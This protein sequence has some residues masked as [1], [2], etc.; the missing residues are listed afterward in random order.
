MSTANN[1]NSSS[2]TTLEDTS[3]ILKISDFI[4]NYNPVASDPLRVQITTPESNGS[5]KYFN[6]TSW[7]DV[8]AKQVISAADI[9]AGKLM[10]VPDKDENGKDYTSIGFKVLNARGETGSASSLKINVTAVNDAAVISGTSTGL[11]TEDSGTYGI[12]GKLSASDIDSAATFVAQNSVKGEYG[13]F[14]ISKDGSWSYTADNAKLQELGGEKAKA[15]ETFTVKTADGTTKEIVVTLKGVDEALKGSRNENSRDRDNDD[16]H[17]GESGHHDKDDSHHGDDDHHESDEHEESEHNQGGAVNHAP[18]VAGALFSTTAEGAASYTLNLLGGASDVDTADTLSVGSIVTYSVEGALASS[19]PPAGVSLSGSTLTVD[20][21]NEAFNNLAVGQ[22]M[23]ILVSYSVIDTKGAS[24]TQ[25]E[26]ITVTGTN[27]GPVAALLTN[28]A[29]EG[30][31][32]V[33]GYVTSTD[34]DA[35]HTAAYSLDAAVAGLTINADGSYSFDPSNAVYQSLAAGETKDVVATYTVTDDQGATS[36]STLIITV[37]GTNDAPVA[38]AAVASATEDDSVVSG[39][40]SATD[41]DAGATVSYA[42][43]AP[44]AGLTMDADGSYSFDP[45]NEAYQSLAAGETKDVVATYTVMDDQGATS[46]STLTITVTGTNDAPVA[47]VAV[48]SATEDDSVVSGAVSATDADAGAT[49]SYALDV[50]VAGLTMDA[51]GSYSFDPSNEAYQSL[52]A[53]EKLDVVATYTVTDDQGATS[54]STLTITVTGTND[55]PVA[56]VAVASATED[57]SVV[58]GAVSATDAD[59]GATASYAL[60][61]PVAGL[62]MDAD[63]SYSFDPSNEAYQ[64]LAAGEKLDVV[65]TYTV[66]DDQGA[67]SSSTLTITV[68]GTNDAP[69]AEVAVASATE[70]DSVVS[71]AVSATDADAGATA[72]YAL[73]VPVAG[74]T[75]DAD[76]SYSFDPSN[77]AY[78]SLAAGEKLD[79]EAHYTVTD[80]QGATSSSTLTITVTGTNDDPTI[81]GLANSVNV[82]ENQTAVTTVNASDPDHNDMLSYSILQTTGTDFARFAIDN[83]GVL[84][85]VSAPDHENPQDIGG[86]DGDNAYVVDVQV[87]DG[88]GGI[89]T[90]TLTVSVQNIL[91]A[92]SPYTGT[93]DSK[94]FDTSADKPFSIT[95]TKEDQTL[96][97]DS[98]ANTIDALAGKDTVYGKEGNDTI[99]GGSGDDNLYGQAGDDTINGGSEKDAIYGG[100][101]NDLIHGNDSND[102]IYGVAAAILSTVMEV[103]TLSMADMVLTRSMVVVVAL[104]LLN[105]LICMIPAMS[106]MTSM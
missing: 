31:A 95:G 6:G 28:S 80:D 2:V 57:D 3:L 69:V 60:D 20:P 33:A 96:T 25:T 90:Q 77:E 29:M 102:T 87:A 34:A 79:V 92:P 59:A 72:S 70:D 97:G 101:G 1:A 37:T 50:P 98:R 65:A 11:I 99:N 74:L 103:R 8:A 78:Q 93:G 85:F 91:D 61:V 76:G 71:G 27:D 32:V 64:S 24:V 7:V 88:H 14:S 12:N 100:S 15:T 40:V 41:A 105:T 21:A 66:T 30:S 75:M 9:T 84:S 47:E 67:T 58:S 94:D 17:H 38:A 4:K 82:N 81:T 23:T 68:T 16:S 45:L 55:A 22:S 86:T 39:A 13:Q 51:D 44:L 35:L 36:S 48:A 10:F 73:D 18:T 53:G 43:D 63:G 54:S 83:H 26:T 46:S 49:A 52:A 62:T 104:T 106:F 89:D 42:L 19:T 5:L 56:E